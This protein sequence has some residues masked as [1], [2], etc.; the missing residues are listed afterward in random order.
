MKKKFTAQYFERK[1]PDYTHQNI[2]HDR[3]YI[4]FPKDN[5]VTS[6]LLNGWLYKEYMFQ[7]LTDNAIPVLGT[8]IIDI[9]ANNGHFTVEFAHLV[10]DTGNVYAFEPQRVIFQQLC[11]NIFINGLDNVHAYNLAIGDKNILTEIE[12]P[13]YFSQGN[14][15]FGDVHVGNIHT[16]K[17]EQ[18]QQIAL[19]SIPFEN[20]SI[21]KIDVQGFEPFVIEGAKNTIKKHRPYIFIE[22]E[23]E[24]LEKYGKS[25]DELVRQIEDLQYVVKR[26]QFGVPYHTK[27]G[28]CLDYVCIPKEKYNQRSYKIR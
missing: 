28:M 9:G 4:L 8:N 2:F 22:V 11:G 27:T 21:I 17:K 12:R 24:Q 3:K 18:I 25:E 19:D 15:N 10:G 7:F 14:V 6:S 23:G 1:R 5:A 13:D 26:F 16:D 20:V